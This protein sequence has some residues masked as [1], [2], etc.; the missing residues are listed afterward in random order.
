MTIHWPLALPLPSTSRPFTPKIIK[1]IDFSCGIMYQTTVWLRYRC[2]ALRR[3]DPVRGLFYS[4]GRSHQ[5][6]VSILIHCISWTFLYA[7]PSELRRKKCHF[8]DGSCLASPRWVSLLVAEL[9]YPHAR[10]P[11][12]KPGT[13]NFLENCSQ[14]LSL[15][16]VVKRPTLWRKP[17]QK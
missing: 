17:F 8:M 15:K 4:N 13:W 12:T 1:V 5:M 11:A 7:P 10:F 14:L 16:Q 2:V 6:F 9:F 3:P